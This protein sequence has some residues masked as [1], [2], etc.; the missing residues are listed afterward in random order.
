[1]SLR[2]THNF[3]E[4]TTVDVGRVKVSAVVSAFSVNSHYLLTRGKKRFLVLCRPSGSGTI[5][6]FSV[7]ATD[8]RPKNNRL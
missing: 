8:S 7:T 1:M 2:E 4:M 5:V 6:N 3:H